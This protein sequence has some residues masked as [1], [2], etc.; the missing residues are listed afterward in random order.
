[1]DVCVVTFRNTA[2]RIRPAIRA[3]DRLW[4]RDNT[5]DNIGFAAAA[6]ELARCGGAEL[7]AFVN[8]DGSPQPDCF[9]ILEMAFSDPDV[10]AA[11]PSQGDAWSGQPSP[12]RLLWVSGA[13]MVV[14]RS[15]F[16]QIGGFDESLWMYGEDVDLSLRLAE[17]GRLAHCWDAVFVH[18]RGKKSFR[19]ER[20]Q[21]RNQLVL[22]CR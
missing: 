15:A 16:E 2:D 21:A 17:L 5:V 12:E 4:V 18:D 11:E 20:L 13:C 6:N 19:A 14:R 22:H 7:I 8:P 1:M 10:V 9:D 3:T